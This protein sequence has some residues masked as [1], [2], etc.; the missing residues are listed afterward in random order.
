VLEFAHALQLGPFTAADV[1]VSVDGGTI[2]TT[3]WARRS[4]GP[5]TVRIPVPEAANQPSVRLRFHY[6]LGAHTWYWQVDDVFLGQPTCE[7]VAGGLLV[8]HTRSSLTRRILDDV[9]IRAEGQWPVTSAATPDDPRLSDG[10]YWLYLPAGRRRVT[11]S[12]YHYADDEDRLRIRAGETVRHDFAVASGRLAALPRRVTVDVRPGHVA[13][14]L[15]TV[16]NTG[17]ADVRYQV[18]EVETAPTRAPAGERD[19]RDSGGAPLREVSAD[20]SPLPISRAKGD[21]SSEKGDPSRPAGAAPRTP[22]QTSGEGLSW[23]DLPDFP[24]PIQASVAGAHGGRIYSF[25]GMGLDGKPFAGSFA[26]D[27]ATH[28]WSQVAEMPSPRQQP[29]GAFIGGRFVVTG[30]LGPGLQPVGATQI[31]DPATDSWSEGAPNPSPWFASGAAVLDG[32]LYVVGGCGREDCGRTDVLRYDLTS[33]T[34]TRVADY[35]QNIAWTSCGGIRGRLYCAG[36]TGQGANNF[37]TFAYDPAVDEWTEVADMPVDLWASAYVVSDER[38]IVAGGAA[39]ES[40]V[41]TNEAFA[42]DPALD[43]WTPMPRL[44]HATYRSAGACGFVRIGGSEGE[45]STTASVEQLPGYDDCRPA[46]DLPWMRPSRTRGS[47]RPERSTTLRIKL[48]ARHI[49]DPGIHTAYLRFREDTPY[50]TRDVR[51]RMIVRR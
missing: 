17:D 33:D 15:L 11:A 5:E 21:A 9:T 50:P 25:G 40:T 42:Y 29:A 49:A 10:F 19:A 28:Q 48:D 30:G 13:T 35:P 38:L 34:W 45:F 36:G 2:W 8:G 24:M 22:G 26:Y 43:T 44:A 3:V 7:P 6:R 41:I 16:V 23:V 1:D 20:I 37:S 14:R 39:H 46:K 18:D 31:Y 4:Q 32:Q 51:I 47:V 27:T 12:T